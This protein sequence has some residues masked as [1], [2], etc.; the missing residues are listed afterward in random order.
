MKTALIASFALTLIGCATVPETNDDGSVEVRLH[1]QVDVGGPKVTVLEVVEDSRCPME[2]RCVWAGRVRVKV[3]V[4]L[5]SDVH[6]YELA[7]D[8]PLPIADGALE[9]TGVMPPRSTQRAI[10][11]GDYRFALKFSGGL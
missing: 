7:S 9:L 5:G 3:W 2:A 8:K 11:P 1:R 10:S 6:F 4:L